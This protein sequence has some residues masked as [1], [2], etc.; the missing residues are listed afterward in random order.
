MVVAVLAGAGS[1]TGQTWVTSIGVQ[2][3][4]G[5]LKPAGTHHNDYFDLLGLPGTMFFADGGDPFGTVF[6]TL[7]L[8]GRFAVEPNLSLSEFS[9][10]L[11]TVSNLRVG[12]RLDVAFGAH[13]YGAV[14]GVVN[15]L[16]AAGG[17]GAA[18]EGP[19][20]VTAAVGYRVALTRRLDGRIE[21]QTTATKGSKNP[22]IT[23]PP[24]DYYGVQLGL[25]EGFRDRGTPRDQSDA[26]WT[27]AIGLQGGYYSAHFQ[28]GGTLVGFAFPGLGTSTG[29]TVATFD[30]FPQTPS[31]VG[32]IPVGGRW[33]VE[34]GF[35][36]GR[37]QIAGPG[38]LTFGAVT[39]AGRADYAVTR[40]WYAG[41][42]PV[43]NSYKTTGRPAATQAG[44]SLAWGYRFHVAGDIAGRTELSY[45]MFS[46]HHV[47][48][49]PAVNLIGLDLGLMMGL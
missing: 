9:I 20:G 49:V 36:M 2:G 41:A 6:A 43:T 30:L 39:L 19:L 27:P 3:G 11:I 12:A 17:G 47:L 7:P 8:G 31:L 10:G 16:S 33:A 23:S 18:H 21:V 25:S 28:G 48:G 40:G 15:Y 32:L 13:L 45:T 26:L 34:A 24:I 44:F 4:F 1:A 5:R 46:H 22:G 14:G 37:T 29:I 38:P 35:G 42:G